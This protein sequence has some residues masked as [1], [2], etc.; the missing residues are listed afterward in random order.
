[1]S[2]PDLPL[3][4]VTPY[5]RFAL[6]DVDIERLLVSGDHEKD[7]VAYFGVEEYQDLA[8]LARQAASTPIRDP[9]LRV[10]LVPGIM[11]S[12][13]GLLRK[14]PLPNDVLWVDPIDIE[15]GRLAALRIPRHGT[16]ANIISLG[17]VIYSYLK[18][19]LHLR[20]AGFAAAFHDY[21]W[22]LGVDELG[23]SFAGR[24]R[25]ESCER[26]AIVAHSMGGLVSRAAV[27]LPGAERVQ[28]VILLGTPN[29]GSFATIQ[30]LRG[31]YAVVRKLARLA[32]GATAESLAG[33]VFNTFPSLYHMLP[34][35]HASDGADQ[36]EAGTWPTSGPRPDPALLEHARTVQ[37]GLARPDSR[38]TCI[39]GIGQETVTSVRR[40]N[41]DFVYT[42][43]R[44][45]D[46]TVPAISA[47]LPGAPAHYAP[48]AHSDLTRD[49]V[50]AATVVDLLSTGTTR[51]LASKWSAKSLAQAQI[52]DKRLRR[53][54]TR[55]VDWAAL[56]PEERRLFLQELN[57]P[58]ALKLRVPA[59][60]KT[61]PKKRTRPTARGAAKSTARARA[62]SKPRTHNKTNSA[63]KKRGTTRSRR[64]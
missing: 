34:A 27:V 32:G 24:L 19:K 40:R 18:L 3:D 46:G 41:D 55:K 10:I 43:T 1:M 15:L 7:L 11:G 49:P 38:F 37:S 6:S 12:Q 64:S 39:V 47:A 4:H 57:E 44:H 9:G 53:T 22:R 48:V 36:F 25:N 60:S 14:P 62:R 2:R 63:R 8:R 51:R 54:H 61:G 21:D 13:L 28:R 45:G 30:A 26:L 20:A 56:E 42:I 29:Y 58:P 16:G 23:R 35:G 50:V 59:K 17:V 52:T 33:E 5:D 31:T